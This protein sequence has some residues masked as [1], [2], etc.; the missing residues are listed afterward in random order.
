MSLFTSLLER[1]SKPP[2][3]LPSHG[4]AKTM[5]LLPVVLSRSLPLAV[6]QI[7]TLGLD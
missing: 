3:V 5:V 4:T 2:K 1:E 7:S 6:G